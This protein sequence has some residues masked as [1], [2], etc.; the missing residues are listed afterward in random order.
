MYCKHRD[1]LSINIPSIANFEWHA[2]TISSSPE[3]PNVMTLHIKVV[4]SWT[5]RLQELLRKD[6]EH[7]VMNLSENMPIPQ[8]ETRTLPHQHSRVAKQIPYE[9]PHSN[10]KTIE[11]Q[12]KR[13][14]ILKP[15]TCYIEG[16]F[17]APAT[18]HNLLVRRL[19]PYLTF[20]K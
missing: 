2:F 17:N 19:C 3:M 9:P 1:W 6:Y 11:T 4:G 18:L 8:M 5:N 15:I 12:Q 10:L 7:M 13:N 16:P 20:L 14:D